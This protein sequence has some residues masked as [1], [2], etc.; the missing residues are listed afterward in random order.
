MAS[1]HMRIKL[2][3]VNKLT[4][5]YSLMS[6]KQKAVAEPFPNFPEPPKPPAP[7]SRIH[8]KEMIEQEYE[9]KNMERAMYEQEKALINQELV[10]KNMQIKREQQER[11]LVNQEIVVI[12]NAHL[13]AST[14]STS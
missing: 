2:K 5:I 10:M 14:P 7:I 4:Y 1:N 6:A 8:E 11:M 9:M 3:D 13:P 12:K